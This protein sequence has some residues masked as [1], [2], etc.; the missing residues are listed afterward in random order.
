MLACLSKLHHSVI[1][2]TDNRLLTCIS[3]AAHA[4]D[5]EFMDEE[6]SP[7]VMK[8][9][10]LVVQKLT[11]DDDEAAEVMREFTAF[12]LG[13]GMFSSSIAV[14]SAKKMGGYEWWCAYGM[15]VVK[16]RRLA[17]R[18]LAQTPSSSACERIWSTFAFV[19]SRLRNR[20]T[21]ERAK[22]L[23][24]VHCNS[25]L[26][27]KLRASKKASFVPWVSDPTEE[28]SDEGASTDGEGDEL[29]GRDE[30]VEAVRAYLEEV[31]EEVSEAESG[32]DSD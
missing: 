13:S 3:L 19:H 12:R 1:P 22:K 16:L 18:I 25:R 24:M 28:D 14:A 31:G 6:L 20:L 7:E 30:V 26:V 5:P 32:S 23:V 15:D 11:K 21:A 27:A 2:H 9:V 8:S 29:E 17:V 10:L 4:L